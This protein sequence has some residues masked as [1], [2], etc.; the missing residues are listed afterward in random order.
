M[1]YKNRMLLIRLIIAI[2]AA[3][4]EI[5]N[6]PQKKSTPVRSLMTAIFAKAF[7]FHGYMSKLIVIF[8][9]Q[10]PQHK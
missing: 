4:R 9:R 8:A 3:V 6:K 1:K 7:H 10:I 5:P 2:C